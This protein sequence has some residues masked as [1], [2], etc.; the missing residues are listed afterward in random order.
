MDCADAALT[1]I[2]IPFNAK[3]VMGGNFVIGRLDNA[4]D[5]TWEAG[6]GRYCLP[7]HQH[8]TPFEPSFLEFNGFL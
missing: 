1:Q 3:N 6:F 4:D 8:P 7:H 5:D 2:V